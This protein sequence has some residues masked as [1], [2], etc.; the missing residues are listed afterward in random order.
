MAQGV[1]CASSARLAT[2]G[3]R[4]MRA[5]I[6]SVAAWFRDG[7]R[8]SK[9]I[10]G[11]GPRAGICGIMAA[12]CGLGREIAGLGGFWRRVRRFGGIGGAVNA[13]LVVAATL[14]AN[15][16]LPTGCL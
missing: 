2:G 8:L 13:G 6:L 11:R 7:V 12:R 16:A 15:H 9:S 10:A 4:W 14:P 5:A 3:L 1:N